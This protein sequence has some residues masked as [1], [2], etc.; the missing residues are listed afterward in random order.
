[1]S[2]VPSPSRGE[3]ELDRLLADMG[4][5]LDPRAY[6]FCLLPAAGLLRGVAPLALLREAEGTTVIVDEA[7][8]RSLGLDCL[9]VARRITLAVHS[10]LVAVGFLAR[11]ASVLAEAGIPC[12]VVSGLY[13]DHLFVPLGEGERACSLLQA[14]QRRAKGLS[15]DAVL[16]EV[17]VELDDPAAEEWLRWMRDVH[18]P[19]VLATGCFAGC[20]ITR[21]I[22]PRPAAG[23]QGFV[24]V[25]RS[26]TL[27]AYNEYLEHHAP[28]LQRMHAKR[29]AGRFV[30]ARRVRQLMPPQG[31]D[32][33]RPG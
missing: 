10:D 24:L 19:D 17:T 32:P 33:G 22:E 11:I 31:E 30:S 27:A 8:G 20:G 21:L 18:V 5:V 2:E 1:M 26:R 3:R 7:T 23:R 4:P 29:Y 9:W 25:Y 12:N 13:H 15:A 6:A 28:R 16:Y 14:L